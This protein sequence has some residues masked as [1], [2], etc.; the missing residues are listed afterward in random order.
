MS[1]IQLRQI[2]R[3]KIYNYR[4]PWILR[5]GLTVIFAYLAVSITICGF[6]KYPDIVPAIADITTINP[7]ANLVGHVTGKIEHVL[8]K[9][10]QKVNKGDV[11]II[12]ESPTKWDDVKKIQT[13]LLIIDSLLNGDSRTY[14]I[15][16]S[17]FKEELKIGELQSAYSELLINYKELFRYYELNTYQKQ[18]ESKQQ[19]LQIQKNYS[20]QLIKKS[21]LIKQEYHLGINSFKRD[22]LLFSTGVIPKSEIEQS[23]QKLLQLE[24]AQTDIE[25][26]LI[27]SQSTLNQLEFDITNLVLQ[28]KTNKQQLLDRTRQSIQLLFSQ[29]NSWKQNYLITSPIKGIVSFNTFWSENQNV[30]AGDIVLSV[31]PD[32]S[33]LVKV[34]IQFPIQNSGKVHQGQR[35]NI[36]LQNYPYQ[37][38]GMLVG[39]VG[40]ISRVPN[41]LLYSADVILAKGLVTSYGKKLTIIKQLKGNAEILTDD[42]SLLIRFF[43]PLKAL[44]YDNKN[45]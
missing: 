18:L 3:D 42:M 43:N 41:N 35:V 34:R 4:P 26:N 31:V 1:E 23:R 12:L 33:T 29:I 36:K 30:T 14:L 32:D 22:S 20:F 27:N 45:N 10:E 9:D 44:L 39:K 21:L 7:P 28:D 15:E 8:T 19:Q 16:P 24:S 5:W 40:T 25:M 17:Y 13:Y 11:L 38:F 37:E 2:Y 6:I